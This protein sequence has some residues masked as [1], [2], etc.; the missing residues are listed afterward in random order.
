MVRLTSWDGEL[1]FGIGGLMVSHWKGRVLL[2][3]CSATF[4]SSCGVTS[5]DACLGLT[6]D[7]SDDDR[8]LERP[9][10]SDV[11]SW[12]CGKPN[13]K[14]LKRCRA[15]S[16]SLCCARW[17]WAQLLCRSTCSSREKYSF[18]TLSGRA[19][20][21]SISGLD[22]WSRC[23]WPSGGVEQWCCSDARVDEGWRCPDELVR[24]EAP[25]T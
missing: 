11:L 24:D 12:S 5:G 6:R 8:L 1:D 22:S 9:R 15:R 25:E 20:K 7:D 19:R 17:L 4:S 14:S 3:Q 23:G 21:K 13:L 16:K 10:C 2:L 18:R